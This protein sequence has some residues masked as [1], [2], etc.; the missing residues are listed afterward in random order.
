MALTAEVERDFLA[1]LLGPSLK[2]SSLTKDLKIMIYSDQRV[3]IKEYVNKVCF[4]FYF[5]D[6]LCELNR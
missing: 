4:K 3:G 1:E 6:T 5:A 2:N